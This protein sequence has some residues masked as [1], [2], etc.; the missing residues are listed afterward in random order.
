MQITLPVELFAHLVNI[1]ARV[2]KSNINIPI[3]RNILLSFEKDHMRILATDLETQLSAKLEVKPGVTEKFTVHSTT[4]AQY[5]T[6]LS[7]EQTLTLVKE[8]KKLVVKG[9]KSSASFIVK[10]ADE[11]PTLDVEQVEEVAQL[12]KED[13]INAL[14]RTLFA[15]SKDDLRPILT[16]VHFNV[17]KDFA[18]L[19]GL[20]T[21]RLSWVKIPAKSKK[22]FKITVPFTGLQNLL[23]ILKDGF[24]DTYVDKDTVTILLGQG[25]NN[26]EGVVIFRYGIIDIT[27]RLLEGEY[28]NY[29]EII[30]QENKMKLSINTAQFTEALRRA[31]IFAQNS[32]N[33]RVIL[34]IKPKKMYIKAS[35]EETG[36]VE[37][38][39]PIT[40]SGELKELT[41]GFQYRFLQ[42]IMSILSTDEFTFETNGA[43]NPAIFREK[44]NADFIHIVMP[45]KL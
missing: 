28:P 38:E 24:L 27:V 30:P 29:K 19:V 5:L 39:L 10:P 41:V 11:Y 40:H 23:K 2:I 45:L 1:S 3:L 21:Y 9:A 4:F 26:T 44:D 36:Q 37:E 22:E 42:D 17:S 13:L 43:I 6:S 34:E 14:D 35:A 32:V 18:E 25:G 7:Q 15:V 12:P 20:D 31:G 8:E 16:G 33:Q